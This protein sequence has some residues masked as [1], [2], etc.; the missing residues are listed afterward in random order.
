MPII[1]PGPAGSPISIVDYD[2]LQLGVA[3][4]LH[5]DDLT[6][7]IPDFIALAEADMNVRCKLVDFETTA[8]ITI[9][10]GFGTLPTG[11]IGMRSIYWDSDP[12]YPLIYVTPEKF[13]DLRGND[14]GDAYYY[15]IS[16][17]TVRTTPMGSGT[18]VATYLSQFTSLSGSNETNS[19]LSNFPDAYLY[20]ACHHG[21]V[22]TND[23]PNAQKYLGLF[24]SAIERI[25]QN[26]ADKKWAGPLAV[27]TR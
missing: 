24:N 1:V 26:N 11:F 16:G 14:S 15:T 8:S 9:T 5:R 25:N 19:L 13:D 10:S 17:T 27:R 18:A 7:S 21:C 4:W 2:S 3:A 23:D 6:A 12:D 20:G 22:Y